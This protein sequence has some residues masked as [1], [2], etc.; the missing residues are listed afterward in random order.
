MT[1]HILEEAL[2]HI[3]SHFV[4]LDLLER[5]YKPVEIAAPEKSHSK[6]T[7]NHNISLIH[8]NKCAQDA[9]MGETVS[10]NFKT[11]D[12]ILNRKNRAR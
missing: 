7:H 4:V 8:A 6:A 2:G 12:Q 9:N 3:R 10:T 11:W 5:K 1:I